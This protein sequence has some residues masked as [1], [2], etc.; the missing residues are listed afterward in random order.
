MN[1]QNMKR[2]LI[3]AVVGA[4][5][6]TALKPFIFQ[7]IILL[8][9]DCFV[10]RAASNLVSNPLASSEVEGEMLILLSPI[11]PMLLFAGKL[12][13]FRVGPEWLVWGIASFVYF[14]CLAM[15]FGNSGVRS[16]LSRYWKLCFI[17]LLVLLCFA[18][19]IS[20]ALI[21]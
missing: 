20:T 13:R 21:H 10:S 8:G 18:F 15:V 17:L 16:F 6:F 4:T 19:M 11:L 1:W 7:F 2:A 3:G 9:G 5:I 12:N 14:F